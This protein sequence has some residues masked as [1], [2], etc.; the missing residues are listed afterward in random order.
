MNVNIVFKA[1][2]DKNRDRVSDNRRVYNSACFTLLL[3]G[4]LTVIV[5]ILA[6]FSCCMRPQYVFPIFLKCFDQAWGFQR[7]ILVSPFSM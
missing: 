2:T 5:V 7:N 1:G 6:V 4:K 3:C